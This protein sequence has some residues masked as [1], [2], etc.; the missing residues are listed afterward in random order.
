[1]RNA[2]ERASVRRFLKDEHGYSD[3]QLNEFYKRAE[4]FCDSD[5]YFPDEKLDYVVGCTELALQYKE[6]FYAKPALYQSSFA[7]AGLA[8]S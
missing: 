6:A 5:G 7:T 2:W 8:S 1:M 3:E 4:P